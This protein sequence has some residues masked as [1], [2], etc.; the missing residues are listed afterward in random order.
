MKKFIGTSVSAVTISALALTACAEG[1]G[2]GA[3]NYPE[4]DIEILVGFGPGG[5]TDIF[6]RQVGRQIENMHDVSVQVVNME[7]A[8]GANAVRAAEGRGSD[9]YTWVAD[10]SLAILAGQGEL[11]EEG[12]EMLTPVARLEDEIGHIMTMPDTYDSWDDFVAASEESTLRVGGVGAGG[13][14]DVITHELIAD[15]GLDIEYVPFDGVGEL[16]AALQGGNIDGA[17]EE[18]GAIPDYMESGEIV[19]I[20]VL[21][22]ETLEEFE[23]IP[24]STDEG[25]DVT[26]G[27]TRGIMVHP[28][29]DEEVI[30]EIEQ[31]L[32]NVYESDEYQEHQEELYLDMRP[33]WMG[34][35]E[36]AEF[37]EEYAQHAGEVLSDLGVTD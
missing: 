31:M 22:D 14:A 5:G 1:S 9:G 13:P 15:T 35:E 18:Y 23:E 12:H 26:S 6:A 24:T 34:A 28:D 20:L 33:G 37:T 19:S 25:I 27:T 36:Y 32:E 30:A 2:G 8:G 11:G 4:Q 3:E 16:V 17:L 21:H 10:A 7:G 29:T